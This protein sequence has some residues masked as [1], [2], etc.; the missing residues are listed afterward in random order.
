MD[1]KK[2][3][4]E[5]LDQIALSLQDTKKACA[6]LGFGSVGIETDRM[7]EYSDL[8]FLVVAK[9]GYKK[10]LIDSLEWLSSIAPIGY[11]FMNT[12]D[13]FKL[14]FSDGIYCE[15]GVLEKEE[16]TGVPHS[17]GRVIWSEEG[18]DINIRLANKNC[19]YESA[20]LNWSVGEI[21]TNLYV[22]LCRYARGEK[23][24]AA[25]F[26]QSYA[27]D[28]LLSCSH[29]FIIENLY[30]KDVFQNDRRYEMRYPIL[31]DQLTDMMQGY[32]KS[33]ESA[34]AI[35]KVTE[36]YFNVDPFIKGKIVDLAKKL[37][38]I[39]KRLS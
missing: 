32:E 26:I 31:A 12:K 4:L 1:Y 16:M 23:L 29:A 24:T 10:D 25:K 22:G 39:H 30:F 5:R 38:I 6:L 2:V 19:E 21:L 36:Q 20:D 15:F 18:F 11:F 33:P 14:F 13:G 35:L 28:Q 37:R 8:D 34:L 3:L 9:K 7:D 27:L 17:E